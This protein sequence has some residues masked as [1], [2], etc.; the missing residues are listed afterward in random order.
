MQRKTQLRAA[1]AFAAAICTVICLNAG[2]SAAEQKG[3]WSLDGSRRS[4]LY[5]DESA[6][7]GEITIDGNTYLFAPNGVQKTAFSENID[8]R[9]RRNVS[10]EELAAMIACA[11][12]LGLKVALKPTAN[13]E[14]GTWR[15]HINFFDEDVEPRALSCSKQNKDHSF[16]YLLLGFLEYME[17]KYYNI[18]LNVIVF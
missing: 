6:A 14:D 12:Q 5:A 2:A 15:A 11:K 4:Y 17:Q 16:L 18:Y 13:C 9:T 1:L 8:Y 3:S 10:D 7:V